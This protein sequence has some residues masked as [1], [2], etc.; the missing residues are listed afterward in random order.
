MAIIP[1]RLPKHGEER[2][3]SLLQATQEVKLVGS[4]LERA[5]QALALK[6]R[7]TGSCDITIGAA[8]FA[9]EADELG[10][11]YQDIT[12]NL[13]SG[14][15]YV[16]VLSRATAPAVFHDNRIDISVTN[17]GN[18]HVEAIGFSQSLIAFSHEAF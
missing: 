13:S 6:F 14:D 5:V 10:T 15:R 8:T 7:A 16:I 12:I 18:G 9:N 4:S 11:E 1:D 2:S 3:D 17:P